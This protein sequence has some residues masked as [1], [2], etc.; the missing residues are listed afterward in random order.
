MIVKWTGGIHGLK[1]DIDMNYQDY[2][3]GLKAA[4]D[5]NTEIFNS[6]PDGW[7]KTFIPQMKEELF[8]VLGS[9]A[10]HWCV[11]YAKEKYGVLRVY[12]CWDTERHDDIAADQEVLYDDIE[13]VIDKYSRISFRTCAVCGSDA[14]CVEDLPLCAKCYKMF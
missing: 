2:I 4:F 5:A 12:W 8:E 10:Q 9:N 1:E 14:R 6:L 13:R 7:V 3:Q 11:L